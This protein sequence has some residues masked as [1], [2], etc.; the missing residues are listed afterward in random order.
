L[1]Y[2]RV[3]RKDGQKPTTESIE[4]HGNVTERNQEEVGKPRKPKAQPQSGF[5][6]DE[7][8][9]E[10]ETPEV[11]TIVVA[12]RDSTPGHEDHL[13]VLFRK[14]SEGEDVRSQIVD[15]IVG[16]FRPVLRANG[17]NYDGPLAKHT[18]DALEAAEKFGERKATS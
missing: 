16:K 9:P 4:S 13:T 12:E 10:S 3:Q 6:F 5:S 7:A 1:G 18:N 2:E 14:Y 8:T 11:G 17:P 15:N